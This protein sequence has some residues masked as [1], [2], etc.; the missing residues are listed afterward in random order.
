[1][2][3]QQTAK[4]TREIGPGMPAD[5]G[6]FAGHPDA[7][8]ALL[9]AFFRLLTA[10]RVYFTPDAEFVGTKGDFTV[11][12]LHGNMSAMTPPGFPTTSRLEWTASATLETPGSSSED[13]EA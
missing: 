2:S 11:R 5:V 4:I 1:M 9:M 8:A 12:L 3:I 7:L 10:E 6:A 13:T